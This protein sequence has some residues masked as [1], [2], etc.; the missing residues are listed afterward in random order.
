MKTIGISRLGP[1]SLSVVAAWLL[2]MTWVAPNASAQLFSNLQTF[3]SR[4][5]AGDPDLRATNSLDGPKGIAT[6]DFDD[7]GRPDLAVAN[8]DGTVTVY[9]GRAL[10]KFGPPT[11]LYTGAQELRGIIAADL[12]GDGQPDI[13]VA[14]PYVGEVFLF[15][16]LNGS[17]GAPI[18]L[19]AWAGARNLAAGDFDG[20][21]LN[22][23]VLGGTTNGLR[24]LRGTGGGAFLTV[25][26]IESLAGS[27][28][29]FPKPLFVLGTF[30]P[31]G[32]SR[33]EAVATHADSKLLWV[34]APD[35]SGTLGITAILTNQ[36]VHAVALGR[37]LATNAAASTDLVIASR[38]YGTI[39]VHRGTNGPGRFQ[40]SVA[41]RIQV[42]GG[43]RALSLAD[44]DG[45]GWNDLVVVLRNFD[46]VLTYHNSNGVFIASTEIPVGKSPRELVT[47]DFNGDGRPDVAV[48][49]RSS[50]DI[51]VLFTYPGQTGF[52][53]LDQVY[54]VD[55]E[56][57][58]LSLFDFNRDGRADVIQTHRASGE[59]SVRMTS[60]NGML[61]PP[62]FFSMGSRPSAQS[63][64]DVNGDGFPDVVTA[65]LGYNG[66][67]SGSISARLGDG[68]GGFGP[69]VQSQ[70]PSQFGGGLFALVAA[71]FDNDGKID[72]AAGFYDCRVAFFKG[73]GNGSFTFTYAT[74]FVYESR[75]MV[76]GDFDGDGDI[77][78]AGAGYAG[79]VVVFENKG[80]L[81]DGT[82]FV[83]T[84]YP[85]PGSD[86]YGTRDIVATDVNGD[87]DL[88]LLVGSGRGTM[89]F[90][91]LP[92][93][94]F[95]RVSDSLPG[96]DF[97]ASGVTTGDF[98]G[99]GVKDAVVSCNI[100][101]CVTI[102]K[103][104]TNGTFTPS[105]SVDV[106]SGQFIAAGDLDGDGKADLVGTGT[107]LWT[108]L[109]SRRAQSAAP[110][111][112]RTA[113]DTVSTLVINEV[114]AINTDLPLDADGDRLSDWIELYN[115]SA[116][117]VQLN[118]WKL[119]LLD[120]TGATTN[121]FAF[122]PTAFFAPNTHLLVVCSETRRTTYH[123]GFRLP[124]EGG[125]VALINPAGVAVETVRYAAQQENVSYARY[126]DGLPSFTFN[127]YPSPSRANTDNGPVEPVAKLADFSPLPVAPDAPIR[128]T[129]TGRDDIGIIGVS[130]LWQRMD[131]ADTETHRLAL[132]DDGE[133]G[134]GG[135]LDG[136]FAGLLSPGLPAG[137]EIQFYLEVTDLSEQTIT[138]PNDTVFAAPGQAVSLYS[139]AVGGL[140]PSPLE[141]S[142]F[143]AANTNGLRDEFGLT[144]DWVEIRNTSTSPVS[145]RG[146][147][148]ARQFFGNGTR[149][150]F[151]AGDTLNPGEHRVIYCD[152]TPTNGPLHAPFSLSRDG[153]LLMLTGP[154][155]SGARALLDSVSFGPQQ[156]DVALARLGHGGAWRSTAPTPRAPNIP[157]P[158]LG[159]VSSNRTSFTFAFPTT[160]NATYVVEHASSLDAPGWTPLPPV[161]GDGLEQT[162]TQP[163]AQSHFYRVRRTP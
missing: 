132:F 27:N 122:P 137:A 35:T 77:D 141:I 79:D 89:L 133:H 127:P 10:G 1:L 73:S 101:S 116:A 69:E 93:M 106:P 95:T 160:T 36:N 48:M 108:A 87:G 145:L 150:A 4:L 114:L 63:A 157:G 99:D 62:S 42:P 15:A 117:A 7:D 147:S 37:V 75:V 41:Q 31:S 32:A 134:D 161:H 49:N 19:P 44:L 110:S 115:A 153:D 80:G 92:G 143:V 159:L 40:Q 13:A 30:R 54:P 125:T 22:D 100:L 128:F 102:L 72:L 76:T 156:T 38:D 140:V 17:F 146:V 43:P 107:V 124:G 82:A 24:Q 81:L 57:S 65:N 2:G 97:P 64:V 112:T 28:L 78:L 113:R 139:L 66:L 18:T 12:T 29:E 130:L 47:A 14:A 118:G 26:N 136:T 109:S 3:S 61:G 8:T 144:P 84:V 20:D 85:P 23:L 11:H 68:T 34:L 91:G 21:G 158:W 46:R 105:I 138:S 103:G 148:L 104:T 119:R 154:S 151:A 74:L 53:A 70:L 129:V 131:V 71:D 51:S 5:P 33:D 155:T 52:A 60:T 56:V 9:F 163:L 39:E 96:T 88:D 123:T 25:T 120:G 55:G 16:N 126:R 121:E 152:G 50:M 98:D 67:S 6:A 135:M 142:E 59:I 83:R 90:M 45:D 86:K 58:G 111:T 149:Y 94:G 162:V